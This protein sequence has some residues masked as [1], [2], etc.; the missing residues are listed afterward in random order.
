MYT[1]GI[2]RR[3]HADHLNGQRMGCASH[4]RR[5]R[6]STACRARVLVCLASHVTT[7]HRS[8]LLA[9]HLPRATPRRA[10]VAPLCLDRVPCM[11]HGR[12]TGCFVRGRGVPL[13]HD[14]AT[15]RFLSKLI[16]ALCPP[17]VGC[18]LLL[19]A[20]GD[21]AL[22]KAP[23]CLFYGHRA[24]LFWPRRLSTEFE[25]E[26]HLVCVRFRLSLLQVSF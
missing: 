10:L 9:P 12:A 16:V 22:A 19:R 4:H 18:A 1:V 14:Q 17:G 6:A 11:P 15:R 20:N 3:G 13:A 25:H 23:P 7:Q 2:P 8:H 26:R 21:C 24:L 5:V